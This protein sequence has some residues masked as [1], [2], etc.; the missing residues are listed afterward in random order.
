MAILTKQPNA[1]GGSL[2][3]TPVGD[4]NNFNTVDEATADDDTT[5]NKTPAGGVATRTDRFDFDWSAIGNLDTIDQI[6]VR[7]RARLGPNGLEG[8]DQIRPLMFDG[9]LSQFG[10]LVSPT[11]TYADFEETF[12][13]GGGDIMPDDG[14]DLKANWEFG[15]RCASSNLGDDDLRVTRVEVEITHTPPTTPQ[16]PVTQPAIAVRHKVV[17]Y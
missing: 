4:T 12:S 16:H 7:F 13:L 14:A 6:V 2:E 1:D 5:Y 9:G 3:C 17:A 11:A 15:Y 8:T 10:N